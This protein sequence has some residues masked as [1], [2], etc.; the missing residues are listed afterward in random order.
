MV[1]HLLLAESGNTRDPDPKPHHWK[2]VGV[3]VKLT[4][5]AIDFI[6]HHKI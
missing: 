3:E 2:Q 4:T 5:F 1:S 6:F